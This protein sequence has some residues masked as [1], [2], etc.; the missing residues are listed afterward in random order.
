MNLDSYDG[1]AHSAPVSHRL[2]RST[3]QQRN[4]TLPHLSKII[5]YTLLLLPAAILILWGSHIVSSI[6]QSTQ[7]TPE[8]REFKNT[9]PEHVP[10]KIKL[11]NEQ[12]FKDMKNKNWARDLEIE[13]KNTG[14]KPI[15]FLYMVVYLP[16]VIV[17]GYPLGFQVTY[18]RMELV[19]FAAPI[20]PDDVPIRPGE[21]VTLKVSDTQVR[22]YEGVRDEEN[23]V[24]PKRVEF[25]MQLINFGD[26]T[27][28]RSKRG[29]PFP[30]PNR[31]RSLHATSPHVKA[32]SPPVPRIQVT[33]VS[34]QLLKPSPPRTRKFSAGK[35][36]SD[37]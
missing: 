28:L 3:D 2:R 20:Q 25:D 22:A 4:N 24:N 21:S 23:L 33:N 31:K 18:G 29:A 11:K 26:G 35:F 30:D 1:R 9:I 16:E 10:L 34:G 12:A 19:H 32:A 27:G 17:D 6:A 15:Y 7:S 37:R 8:E 5:R 13:V 14:N 36:F